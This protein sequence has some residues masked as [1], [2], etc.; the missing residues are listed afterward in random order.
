[1]QAMIA[2]ARGDAAAAHRA[3]EDLAAMAAAGCSNPDLTTGRSGL[4]LAA[5][6][7]VDAL[8]DA[9]FARLPGSAAAAAAATTASA[10]VA[11]AGEGPDRV[12]TGAA[13]ARLESPL[14]NLGEALLRGLWQEIEEL[15]PIS[16]CAGRRNL[17]IAHGW[18]GYLFATLQWCRATGGPLPGGLTTRIDQLAAS[19]SLWQRG[20][21][22]QWYG[23]ERAVGDE[24]AVGSM[25]GWC[26]GSAG[27]AQLFA[28]AY[29]M[30]RNPVYLQ[31]CEAAAWNA[32]EAPE[33]G[34]GS[35]CCGLAGRA[36]GLLSLHRLLH[37]DGDAGGAGD[38]L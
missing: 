38:W 37:A 11:A 23:R 31:V 10:R 27:M 2:M 9:A 12:A 25:A 33:R 17:G 34:G 18:A 24:R 7:L 16:Q 1:V 6:L 19:G 20:L 4:L 28:L 32:W 29:R 14:L 36:Y 35:L 21:R 3:A 8:G 26:N 15:P 5:T 22:W 13:A 30:L